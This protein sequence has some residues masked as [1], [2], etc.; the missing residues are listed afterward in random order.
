[1]RQFRGQFGLLFIQI[2]E[3]VPPDERNSSVV[4]LFIRRRLRY[5]YY[6]CQNVQCVI[7]D[8]EKLLH[9]DMVVID[10][11]WVKAKFWIMTGLPDMDDNTNTEVEI[12]FFLID[13]FPI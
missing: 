13:N 8:S 2:L 12:R 10:P 3:Y 5:S 6:Q 1:M 7:V 9:P 4:S 11:Y